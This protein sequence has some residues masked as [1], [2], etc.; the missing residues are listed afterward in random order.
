MSKVSTA[1][2]G[3]MSI[4]DLRHEFFGSMTLTRPHHF[5]LLHLLLIHEVWEPSSVIHLE[6]RSP[7]ALR[8][9]DTDH[10]LIVRYRVNHQRVFE[11][12]V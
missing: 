10:K 5:Y 12:Q 2:K 7:R 4:T 1:V 11:S 6:C 8:S 9:H 3:G